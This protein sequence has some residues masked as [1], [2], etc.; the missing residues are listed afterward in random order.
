MVK[1]FLLTLAV[2][3]G[4]L[5][6]GLVF[7]WGFGVFDD[8]AWQ[9]DALGWLAMS[10]AAFAASHHPAVYWLDSHLDGRGGR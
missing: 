5:A 3:C 8:P 10:V 6:A 1:W 4:L 7:G 9:R 2:C